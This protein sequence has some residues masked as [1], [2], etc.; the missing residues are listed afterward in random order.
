MRLAS[1][2]DLGIEEADGNETN[3]WTKKKLMAA[4]LTLR[5]S[6]GVPNFSLLVSGAKLGAC[7]LLVTPML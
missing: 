7:V 6:A 5:L 4:N 3:K 2:N 1:Q